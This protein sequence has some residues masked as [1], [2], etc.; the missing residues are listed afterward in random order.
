M[1]GGGGGGGGRGLDKC[2]LEQSSNY[3]TVMEFIFKAYE[4]VPEAYRQIFRNCKKEIDK[5]HVEFARTKN[6]Y[7][8][9]GVL[10]SDHE[11]LR[12]L[13]L[14]EEFNKVHKLRH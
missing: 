2:T 12:Q 6:S 11:T 13:M 8:T 14:V 5:S 4:F 1:A 3:D 7:L 9:G 10:G